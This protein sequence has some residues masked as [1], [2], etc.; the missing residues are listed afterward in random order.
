MK[1]FLFAVLASVVVMS[2]NAEMT[3]HE[4]VAEV[5]GPAGC[6][7][8]QSLSKPMAGECVIKKGQYK[9]G[10]EVVKVGGQCRE[11]TQALTEMKTFKLDS[12][13]KKLEIPSFKTKAKIVDCPV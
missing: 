1:R 3:A 4:Y 13:D 10:T 2:A 9:T 8:P 7:M 11:I 12:D 6:K 5:S